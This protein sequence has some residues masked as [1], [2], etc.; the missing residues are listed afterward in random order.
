M[1]IVQFVRLTNAPNNDDPSLHI[2]GGRVRKIAIEIRLIPSN[3]RALVVARVYDVFAHVGGANGRR[4]V[5]RQEI[6]GG[7]GLRARPIPTTVIRWEK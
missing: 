1:N 4:H 7:P 6:P 5:A 2:L 3:V